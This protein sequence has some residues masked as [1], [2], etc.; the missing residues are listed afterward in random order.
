MNRRSRPTVYIDGTVTSRQSLSQFLGRFWPVI[1]FV[2][3]AAVGAAIRAADSTTEPQS[4]EPKPTLVASPT[5]SAKQTQPRHVTPIPALKPKPVAKDVLSDSVV[6]VWSIAE[7]EKCGWGSGT[8]V[9]DGQH[10]LTNY[11]VVGPDDQCDPTTIEIWKSAS[12][13]AAPEPAFVAEIGAFDKT[14]D[15]A[16]LRIIESIGPFGGLVPVSIGADVELGS[17]LT[18]AGFP[19]IGGASLTLSQ[20]IVAGFTEFDG[21]SW[22]KTDATISGGSSG[23]AAL[24]DDGY[25]VGIPTMASQ[26]E[27]GEVVD[28]RPQT[29]SNN[30]GRLDPTDSCTP[31]GGFF[32]LLSPVSDEVLRGLVGRIEG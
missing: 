10:V 29:D 15:L 20:G 18:L 26:S 13:S 3:A 16:L 24:T 21:A 6:Q 25:L 7:G 14:R 27:D 5:T 12:A 22:V 31:I 23:G 4:V 1:I 11:H 9:I 2:A 19:A 8:A 28:C 32:N 30:N 17:E